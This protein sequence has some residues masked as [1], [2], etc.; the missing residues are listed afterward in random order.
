MAAAAGTLNLAAAVSDK[1]VAAPVSARG[2]TK[3]EP[4]KTSADEDIVFLKSVVEATNVAA[5]TRAV[6]SLKWYVDNSALCVVALQALAGLALDN[7]MC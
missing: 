1:K 2:I 7:G 3:D 4:P 5:V 6:Q